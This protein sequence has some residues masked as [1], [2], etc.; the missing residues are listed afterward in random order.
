LVVGAYQKHE[1][2]VQEERDA[3]V[4]NH[5][6]VT[7]VKHEIPAKVGCLKVQT[8]YKIHSRAHRSIVVQ[9]DESIHLIRAEKA[10]NEHETRSFEA[11]GEGLADEAGEHEA[12]LAIGGNDDAEND[13]GDVGEGLAVEGL[14]A[15]APGDQEDDYWVRGLSICVSFSP[16]HD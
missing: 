9:R 14:E 2:H 16:P 10:L 6:E 7:D 12:D 11:C 1:G 13:D 8:S 15:E 3:R 4:C 5:V